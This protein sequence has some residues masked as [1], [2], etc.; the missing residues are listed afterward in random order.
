[1]NGC[2]Q[3]GSQLSNLAHLG[4]GYTGE[5]VAAHH[6]NHHEFG[7]GLRCDPECPPDKG[8]GLGTAGDGDDDPLAGL[9]DVGD[10]LVGT[11]FG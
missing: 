5:A 2:A 4:C 10:V 3:T 8:F 1:M 6:V 9:P 7:A 11:V